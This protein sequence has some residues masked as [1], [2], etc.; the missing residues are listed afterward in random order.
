MGLHPAPLPLGLIRPGEPGTSAPFLDFTPL[1]AARAEVAPGRR[2]LRRVDYAPRLGA[3]RL[4][5]FS[6]APDQ[7]C[8]FELV[9]Q[10]RL[11]QL[12][13]RDPRRQRWP[14]PLHVLGLS[15]GRLAEELGHP[16]RP[17]PAV[18][19]GQRPAGG[20]RRRGS[21]PRSCRRS[22]KPDRGSVRRGAAQSFRGRGH[23]GDQAAPAMRA[24][25]RGVRREGLSA[26]LRVQARC[27]ASATA[28]GC[29]RRQTREIPT[30]SCLHSRQA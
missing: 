2:I 6:L 24:R 18:A 30:K 16:D 8:V 28:S 29:Q 13:R 3:E 4:A 1:R 14:W 17:P 26:M 9:E 15:G 21:S 27:K 10:P 23:G 19:A 22:R 20:R 25:R 11:Q 5:P 7:L 12:P